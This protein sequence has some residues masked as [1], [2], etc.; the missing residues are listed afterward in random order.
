MHIPVSTKGIVIKSTGSWY[1]VLDAS[2]QLHDC[3]LRGKFKMEGLKSTNPIAV[4]DHVDFVPDREGATTGSIIHIYDRRNYI[5]R[6]ATK[7]SRQTHIIAANIDQAVVIATVAEPRTSTGFID[8]L[9]VTCEAYSIKATVVFNKYDLIKTEE[10]RRLLQ[11]YVDT[12]SLAGYPCMKVSAT[13]NIHLDAFKDLL[14]GKTSL[15]AGHS[16]VGKSTLI[17][18]IE[19]A[20]NLKVQSISSA[21]LKGKHTTTFAEMIPL[22][23][24]GFIIDTPGIKEFGLVDFQQEDLFHYFPEMQALFNQCRYDNCTHY[25]EPGCVVK[26]YVDEGKISTSRY[27]NYINMLL[28]HDTRG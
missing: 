8:R 18:A 17:N 7:L 19:A 12:Y 26:Q 9:L 5:I 27:S 2:G 22:S 23:N 11:Q 20:V 16:G 21:H 4:G 10:D 3:R 25:N 1:S 14:R 15:L 6:K 13:E 24:G 28:K